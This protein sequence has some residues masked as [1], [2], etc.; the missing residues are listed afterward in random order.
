MREEFASKA[1]D[2][3]AKRVGYRC[4]NPGCR[5]LTS[6]PA[7][8]PTRALNMGV[9]AHI[10]AASAGGP[11]YDS[12]L[13]AGERSSVENGTWLCQT[14]GK[15]VDS[16]DAR[17]TVASIVQWKQISE[18]MTRGEIEQRRDLTAEGT[19][20][21]RK[22][23]QLMPALLMEMR[24]DL[25]QYPLRREFVVMKR[26]VSYWAKGNELFY[27]FDD[28]DEL[29]SKLQILENLGLVHEITY[30]NTKRFI[31]DEDLADYLTATNPRPGPSAPS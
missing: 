8:D 9:A 23:E 31:F 18:A 27:F 12:A 25:A 5:Q 15:L 30:N 24:N 16:D 19:P 3:L 26:A 2:V 22:A 28:H 13:S 14:C 1:K 17:F 6:G 29:L 20:N 10:T 4:A 21:F 7:D 11:R